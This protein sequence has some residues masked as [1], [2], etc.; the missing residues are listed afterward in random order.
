MLRTIGVFE[1]LGLARIFSDSA[2]HADVNVV[3]RNCTIA[4]PSD[5]VTCR[6]TCAPITVATQMALKR[7]S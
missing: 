6:T 4:R 5:H 1:D 7:T 3:P 2:V